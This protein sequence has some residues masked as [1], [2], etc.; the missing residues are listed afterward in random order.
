MGRNVEMWRFLANGQ[1][2]ALN[3]WSDSFTRSYD[4]VLV[5]F[6]EGPDFTL[7]GGGMRL[8]VCEGRIQD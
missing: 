8:V 6:F 5:G 3:Y 1:Q 4:Y 7:R 2:C